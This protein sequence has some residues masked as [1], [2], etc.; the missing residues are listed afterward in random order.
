M[1]R[2][3]VPPAPPTGIGPP[4]VWGLDA[5]PDA[6]VAWAPAKVNLTLE[7]LG[8]R[9]D[10]YHA[11]ETL[12]L[13]VDLFDTLEVRRTDGPGIALTCDPPGLPTDSRNLVVKAGEA[14]RQAFAPAAGA[15]VRLTK[16]IPHEAGLGGGS[17]DAATT[18]LAL[19]RV[20][21]LNR[22]PA[23]L[24]AVAGTVGSDVAF[25]L[26]PPAGWCTGRGEVVT[27]EP[28]P[29]GPV[30]LVIVKPAE[31]LST[32]EVYRRV[33][34]PATPTDGN[35]A[36]AAL[37]AGDIEALAGRL[38]NRLQG[39]AFTASPAVRAVFDRLVGVGPLAAQLSGSG[40]AVFAL[41][42]DA[43]HA[44]SVAASYRRMDAT[45]AVFV[46]RGWP[47]V[48]AHVP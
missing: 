13:A 3:P 48:E 9:P 30:H 26:A 27:P 12:I 2:E 32:A 24:A 38:V 42:R 44:R 16:R 25:F 47:G 33:V 6:V 40:S 29:G 39:P 15:A 1:L 21:K 37:R 7:V 36:R 23:E 20:W 18:L 43:Q 35:P 31:G 41:C 4:F 11:V 34:V 28:P 45:S 46:V 5:G 8:K 10:G 22:S 19:N 17:S 14:L